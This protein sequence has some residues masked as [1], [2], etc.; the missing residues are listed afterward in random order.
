MSI[1]TYMYVKFWIWIL[2]PF[3]HELPDYTATTIGLFPMSILQNQYQKH[4]EQVQ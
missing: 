1:G 4:E 3:K 2:R